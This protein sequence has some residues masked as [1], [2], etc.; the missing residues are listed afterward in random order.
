MGRRHMALI[1]D[2]RDTC[3][4]LVRQP[5][6]KRPLERTRSSWEYNVKAYLEECGWKAVNWFDL[7][8][9]VDKLGLL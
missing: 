8:E 5:E 2:S 3:R 1:R 4:I 6:G 9:D 7:A